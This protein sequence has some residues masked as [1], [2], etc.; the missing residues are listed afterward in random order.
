[1]HE[2]EKGT[3]SH[4]CNFSGETTNTTKEFFFGGVFSVMPYQSLPCVKG[5]G[6]VIIRSA[7]LVKKIVKTIE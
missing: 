2:D 1:M 6:Y 4:L 3:A 5:G 7:T